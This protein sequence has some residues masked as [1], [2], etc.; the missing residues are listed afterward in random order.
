MRAN[1]VAGDVRNVRLKSAQQDLTNVVVQLW[2][3]LRPMNV[4]TTENPFLEDSF[5][6]RLFQDFGNCLEVLASLVVDAALGVAS[7][8]PGITIA[9]PLAGQRLEQS[10]ALGQLSEA[11]FEEASA[12]TIDQNDTQPWE[13]SKQVS[14]GLQMKVRVHKKLCAGEVGGQI[15]LLP[16][17]L[18][19]AG[20]DGL[21]VCAI[22]AQFAGQALNAVK[23]GAHAFFLR[24]GFPIPQAIVFALEAP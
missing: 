12:V 14:Q 24:L 21:G 16:N 7:V 8:V 15:V 13:G 1:L 18:G 19:R 3:E 11:K 22:A 5:F 9:A 4:L 10:F 17:V 23:I 6:Q 20:E 2:F